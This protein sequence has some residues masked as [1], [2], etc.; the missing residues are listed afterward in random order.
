MI[1]NRFGFFGPLAVLILVL[2]SA[3]TAGAAEPGD[4]DLNRQI[5]VGRLQLTLQ[6]VVVHEMEPF[7]MSIPSE[8]PVHG[9]GFQLALAAPE[10]DKSSTRKGGKRRPYEAPNWLAGE[11]NTA[12][13]A[14]TGVLLGGCAAL[15]IDGDDE[16]IESVGDLT[17]IV[18]PIAGMGVALGSKDW[19]G[20][21]RYI[22]ALLTSTA[23][24]HWNKNTVDK[25]RP[26]ASNT[27]SFP[28]GHTQASFAGAGFIQRRYGPKWGIPALA[29]A[30]YTAYSRVRA[31]KHF[32]D[33]VI[34]GMSIGC[35]APGSLDTSV[36]YAASA[37]SGRPA[38]PTWRGCGSTATSSRS[39]TE[40]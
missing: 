20:T 13:W 29:M 17:Q 6:G 9:L 23:I 39:P 8:V 7:T 36:H 40:T 21:R 26:N 27:Q 25:Y 30:T 34:S 28:S 1:L 35:T 12:T 24:V 22:Y 10:E 3:A 37:R 19:Q 11:P 31:Q 18:P 38:L 4:L 16:T 33:D 14:T 15:A 5:G 32:T 2:S